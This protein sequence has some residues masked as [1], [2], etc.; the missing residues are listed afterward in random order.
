MYYKNTYPPT[1]RFSFFLLISLVLNG[2][3]LCQQA[4]ASNTH[5][6]ILKFN[7][8]PLAHELIYPDWFKTSQPDLRDDL[9]QAK[10]AGKKGIITYFGQNHCPYCEQ[11]IK[12]SLSDPGIV[13]YLR[14]HYDV[15]AFNIWG[16]DD[17]TDTDGRTYTERGLAIHYKTNFTPSLVFY[18]EKGRAIFRLRGF[19]PPYKFRA[20]LRYVTEGFY[21][22]QTLHEYMA[23]AELGDFFR[24]GGLNE[25]DFFSKPPYNL[26]ALL[27]NGKP[28]S[29]FFEQSHCHACDLLH[30]GPLNNKA[31]IKEL[32]KMNV[33][34]LNMWKNTPVITPNGEK[35]TAKNWAK[36]L[37]IFYAPTLVFFTPKGK[38]IIRIDSVAQF[39]RLFGVLK[40]VN[41]AGY[42]QEKNYQMWRLNQRKINN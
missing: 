36:K 4:H 22:K 16:I 1:I 7:D 15:I 17:V 41:K 19:Y 13:N 29:V 14:L 3:L 5:H 30:S 32:D 28:L 8:H 23:R 27:K 35:T 24:L 37:N 26:P 6:D 18:D 40:Y 25:R 38:E 12:T 21:K 33:I 34:Q 31:A 2:L 42:K 10:K 9:R 20:A 11:F 39:Y